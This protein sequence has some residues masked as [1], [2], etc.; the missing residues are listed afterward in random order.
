MR[1]QVSDLRD[2]QNEIRGGS[3]DTD[4]SELTIRPAGWPSGAGGDEGDAGREPAERVAEG[5]HV[6]RRAGGC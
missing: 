1:D 3:S 4:V 2:G 5:A 6:R